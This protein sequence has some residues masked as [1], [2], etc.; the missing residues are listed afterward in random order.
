MKNIS[1]LYILFI[2]LTCYSCSDYVE[3]NATAPSA[4][5]FESKARRKDVSEKNNVVRDRKIIKEGDISFETES[6]DLTKSMIVKTVKEFNGYI[7]KENVYEY[8]DRLEHELIVRVPAD[9]FDLLLKDISKSAIKIESKNINVIDVTAEFID[10]EARVKNKKQLEE[11]YMELI[12]QATKVSEILEIEKEIGELREEIES[13]EG[14]MNYLKDRIS[15]SKL[16]ITYYQKNNSDF[17]FSNKLAGAF[18]NGWQVFLWFLIGLSNL[19]IFL[20]LGLIT[21]YFIMKRRKNRKKGV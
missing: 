14:Q 4:A 18:E 12:K 7:S 2:G 5:N 17:L 13:V 10:V 1:L 3:N 20:V 21:V 16:T 9:K 8:S 11:R 6:V 19:W 15:L